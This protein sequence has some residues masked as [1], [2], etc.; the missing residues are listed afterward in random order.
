MECIAPRLPIA[1]APD[2]RG[3]AARCSACAMQKICIPK[4][5]D[6]STLISI[7][8]IIRRARSLRRGQYL[9]GAGHT[10]HYLFAVRSGAVKTIMRTSDGREQIVGIYGPGD[11]LGLDGLATGQ[12]ALDAVA[13]DESSICLI[14][15]DMF[16]QLCH[17]VPAVQHRL[18]EIMGQQVIRDANLKMLSSMQPMEARVVAFLIELSQLNV[19]RGFSPREFNIGMTRAEIGNYLGTT[20]E[21]V[22]RVM[23]AL[24]RDR[25]IE[26]QGKRVRVLD[27]DSLRARLDSSS[28]RTSTANLTPRPGTL[29]RVSQKQPQTRSKRQI[30]D[31]ALEQ[32]PFG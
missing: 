21:T 16:R 20:L 11:T 3:D 14:P 18:T 1:A 19:R 5:G 28:T 29:D 15:Y 32:S 2:S 13:T 26:V 24:S 6:S 31:Y 23:S 10:L 17:D 12:H 7:E 27:F 25:V 4:N 22:C 9:Y 30:R 8:A